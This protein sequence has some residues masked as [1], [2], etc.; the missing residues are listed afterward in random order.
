VPSTPL[1]DVTEKGLLI[2]GPRN[3]QVK[4]SGVSTFEST[5]GSNQSLFFAAYNFVLVMRRNHSLI[6]FA[7]TQSTIETR[8]RRVMIDVTDVGADG[9]A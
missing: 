6:A 4:N 9:N 8:R 7:M 1:I 2:R 3:F 5:P